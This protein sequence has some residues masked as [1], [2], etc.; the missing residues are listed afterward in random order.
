MN[1][2]QFSLKGK[3]ALI[4]GGGSGIGLG[5]AKSFVEAGGSV[6]I[7]GRTESTLASA[8]IELG[9]NSSYY[10]FDITNQSGMKKLVL[11]II[12][13]CGPIHTLVNNAGIHLKATVSETTDEG[14]L[15]IIQT[16]LLSSF[17]LSREVMESMKRHDIKGSVIMISSMTGIM[18]M[19]KVVAYTSAK[20]GMLGLMRGLLADYAED[21]IRVNSIAPGWIESKML[22]QA[23]D[24]DT[25]RKN[26]ILNRIPFKHFGK[27]E[28]IGN[29]A[30][31]LASNASV[32]INGVLL[33]VDGAAAVGF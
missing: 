6:V 9:E 31:F 33:P 30:V 24:S 8:C 1:L 27:P 22:H 11:Q 18:A 12:K 26:K 5:I 16:H 20:T 7:I 29:A 13:D 23:L 19:T 3:T 25:E 32:Y 2:S 15:K 4:T 14:F 21:G 28:D 10:V 17:T